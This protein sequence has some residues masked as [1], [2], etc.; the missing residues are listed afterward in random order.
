MAVKILPLPVAIWIADR[1]D[2]R[3]PEF[4]L[5]PLGD[6][7]RHRPHAGDEGADE[8]RARRARQDLTKYEIDVTTK[9]GPG[10]RTRFIDAASGLVAARI[11]QSVFPDAPTTTDNSPA[12][13]KPGQNSQ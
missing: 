9:L 13:Q 7:F 2:L 8:R 12:A 4:V 5:A 3:G 1:G 10:G 6:E 11:A